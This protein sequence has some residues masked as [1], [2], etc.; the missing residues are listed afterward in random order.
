MI[1]VTACTPD[2]LPGVRALGNSI[3]RNA[4]A[5]VWPPVGHAAD[6]KPRFGRSQRLDLYCIG[7]GG[8]DLRHSILEAGFCPMMNTDYPEGTQFPRG[9]Q[10]ENYSDDAMRAMY[11]RVLLPQ[12]FPHEERVLWLDS[13]ILVV[14]SIDELA[15]IDF[16]GHSTAQA[17]LGVKGKKNDKFRKHCCAVLLYNVQEWNK[18]NSTERYLDLMNDYKGKPGGVVE[19]LMNEFLRNDVLSL[20]DKWHCNAKRKTPSREDVIL[21]FPAMKPWAPDEYIRTPKPKAMVEHVT[22]LWEP[23][24]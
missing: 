18:T 20:A 17:F 8:V 12:L 1:I 7:Y 3:R 14:G 13:D 9:G 23:Y 15:H 16:H 24:R 4:G 2:Y 21:H 6:D 11:C 5:Q 10:W 22:K 19:T